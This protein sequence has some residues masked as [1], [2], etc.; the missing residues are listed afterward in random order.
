MGPEEK[1]RS[2]K[3]IPKQV[4]CSECSLVWCFRCQAPW[5]ENLTCKQFLKGDVLL[6]KWMKKREDDQ[7]NA[8]KCPKCSSY[9]QRAGG[10]PH[11]T[12]RSCSCE[13]C[14]LCGRRYR[15]I[16]FIGQHSNRLSV[17]GC[18]YNL[19]PERPWLRRTI[20]GSIATTAVVASPLIITGAA[21]AAI[22][23]LPPLGIYRLVQHVR[24]NRATRRMNMVLNQRSVEVEPDFDLDLENFLNHETLGPEALEILRRIAVL[25]REEADIEENPFADMDV[26]NLFIETPNNEQTE[27]VI[28]ICHESV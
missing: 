11:M 21:V 15:K 14:Y 7:W 23:V 17:F 18:P 10:C 26:E 24:R 5:H 16:P 2:I 22:T 28:P 20:R 8:R 25:R 6:H 19:T 13:F 12:C 4:Q 1:K 3:K 27:S 9:I